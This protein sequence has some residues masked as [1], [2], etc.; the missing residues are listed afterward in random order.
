MLDIELVH[1]DVVAAFLNGKL[2]DTVYMQQPP[3]FNDK[4]GSVFHLKKSI[5]GL[6][7]SAQYF[8]QFIDKL[9]AELKWR[10]L[11]S[12]WAIWFATGSSPFVASYVD[13]FMIDSTVE[14]RDALH[15]FPSKHLT[16]TDLGPISTYVGISIERTLFHG[17][18]FIK[19]HQTEYIDVLLARL[20]MTDCNGISTPMLEA[21]RERIVA[22]KTTPLDEHQ[23]KFYQQVYGTLLYVMHCSQPDLAYI[24][25]RLAQ[26][27]TY[28]EK[29]HWEAIKSLLRYLKATRLAIL[30]L[31][32][33]SDIPL[34]GY[35]DAAYADCHDR[36]ST[37]GY[38][39]LFYGS[40]ISWQS[41][42]Q[43]VIA[44]STTEAEFMAASEAGRE[45][46]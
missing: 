37:G 39:V 45:V 5:Y 34:V 19:I 6:H 10:R 9:M 46:L 18:S 25:I 3:G 32:P 14:Q 7:Q 42:V 21:D 41:K 30:R 36:H 1:W 20:N 28:P 2:E 13:D 29:H 31:S 44:L 12:K 40:L 4:T 17:R 26:Y 8:Y 27:S 15:N 33:L 43:E 11:H 38:I 23:I 16:I 22:A 24:V 35:F